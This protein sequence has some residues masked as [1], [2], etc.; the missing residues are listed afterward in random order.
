[1]CFF[2]EPVHCLNNILF[3]RLAPWVLLIIRQN[4]HIL[5]LIL[6]P[7]MQESRHIL[8]I[9]DTSSQLPT[10]TEVI[11]TNQECLAFPRARTILIT[12]M[13]RARDI[14]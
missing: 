2:D 4:N 12:E 7:L 9:I 6:E 8:D 1:M 10:L 13:S 14:K 5:T 3:G 11:D